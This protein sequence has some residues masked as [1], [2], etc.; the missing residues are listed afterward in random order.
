MVRFTDLTPFVLG[1][2]FR[3]RFTL[4]FFGQRNDIEVLSDSFIVREGSPDHLTIEHQPR[5]Q[6]AGLPLLTGPCLLVRDVMG[7]VIPTFNGEVEVTAVAQSASVPHP[8][9]TGRSITLAQKGQVIFTDLMLT[10]DVEGHKYSLRFTLRG[11]QYVNIRSVTFN[12]TLGAP[13]R[14]ELVTNPSSSTQS[15]AVLSQQP[16]LQI[17][18]LAGNLLLDPGGVDAL[19][20]PA[21]A[22]ID[23][24]EPKLNNNARALFKDTG[25]ARVATFDSLNI[26]KAG[27]Y[28]LLF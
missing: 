2:A 23:G 17:M 21:A 28:R 7:H 10:Q 11:Y 6:G 26:D 27:R 9:L 20:V 14:L 5:Y 3:L 24:E 16:A 22:A 19:L 15:L 4:P 8:V 18:D 12:S 1:G 25:G 13:A